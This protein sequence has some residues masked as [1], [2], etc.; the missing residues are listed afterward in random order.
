MK[1]IIRIAGIGSRGLNPEQLQHCETLGRWVVQ[2]GF[3]LHSG[4]AIGADQAFVRGGASANPE[5]V[6]IHIPWASYE[7][8]NIPAGAHTDVLQNLSS[9]VLDYY[10]KLAQEH[11]P[12]WSR[13][14][15]GGQ[16]LHARNGRIIQPTP[17]TNVDLILA[18]PSEKIGGGGTG[19]GM[20]IGKSLGVPVVDLS[21]FRSREDFHNLCEQIRK[22][23]P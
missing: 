2:Q 12:A 1:Q 15:R 17:H 19:G 22:L 8:A 4:G 14:T 18:W 20:R 3:E 16:A 21:R 7:R 13:L 23:H 5:L 10:R 11:H 9:Q 6:H